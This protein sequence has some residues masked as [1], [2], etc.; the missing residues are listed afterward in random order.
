MGEQSLAE[1]EQHV[2][3]DPARQAQER[4]VGD[5][6]D[7]QREQEHRDD[8]LEGSKVAA[9][10]WTDAF[11]DAQTDQVRQCEVGRGPHEDEQSC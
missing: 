7:G 1:V 4:V 5:G 8:H 11:V 2:R 3:A 9:A 6:V 10:A